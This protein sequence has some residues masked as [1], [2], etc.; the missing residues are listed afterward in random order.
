MHVILFVVPCTF[1]E[2]K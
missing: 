2:I 1:Y